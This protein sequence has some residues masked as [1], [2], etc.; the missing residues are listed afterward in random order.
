MSAGRPRLPI[1]VPGS[2]SVKHD[3][4]T[5]QHRARCRVRLADGKTH[6]VEA[7]GGSKKAAERR[8]A[9]RIK[10]KLGTSG[11]G[12][13][14]GSTTLS[15]LLDAWMVSRRLDPSLGQSSRDE[16]AACITS[17]I[18]PKMGALRL[19]EL[20]A[21]V[22]D[23]RLQDIA[24]A[25]PGRARQARTILRQ[26]CSYGVRQQVWTVSPVHDLTPLPGRK[27]RAK[28]LTMDE[29]TQLRA[30]IAAW[31]AGDPRRSADI[32]RILDL[33][34]ATACR[35]GELTALQWE[36]VALDANPATVTVNATTVYERGR[37]FIRQPHRKGGAHAIT[38]ILPEWARALLADQRH[39]VD[40]TVPWVFP[41]RAGTMRTPHNVRRS[42]RDALETSVLEGTT[43][44]TM[45]A[46]VATWVKRLADLDT[47]SEQL[48][49][50]DTGVTQEH[51]IEQVTMGPDVRTILDRLA[52]EEPT[53]DQLPD[54]DTDSTHADDGSK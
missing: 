39:L 7:T 20:H 12:Q 14:T 47:A 53:A 50:G 23:E 26:A 27:K 41:S 37:G 16:Y 32:G 17:C 30:V 33:A 25:T 29:L 31:Q 24:A 45:R 46:T 5:G 44:H 38:L 9:A 48:G 4:A 35:I 54:Q 8:L 22:V 34:V 13:L 15:N 40:A 51:Y 3:P 43:P 6:H 49:H 21:G 2:I 42:L 18:G 11:T 52:P 36:D 1:G 19:D 10:E 28:A